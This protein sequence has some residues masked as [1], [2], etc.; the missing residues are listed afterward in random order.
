MNKNIDELF[1]IMHKFNQ[2]YNVYKSEKDT[3]L[4]N[5]LISSISEIILSKKLFLR[6]KDVADFL[7]KRFKIVFPDYVY[8]NRA[9]ILGRTIKYFSEFETSSDVKDSLNKIYI[10][11]NDI[12]EENTS[13]ELKTWRDLIDSLNI[14]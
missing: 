14:R 6:N 2:K 12:L 11:L 10:F 9:L 13:S 8:K 4:Y 7:E 5:I 3:I 1:S